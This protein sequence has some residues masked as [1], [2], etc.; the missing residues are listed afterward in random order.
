[1]AE[2]DTKQLGDVLSQAPFGEP[3]V[4]PLAVMFKAA[5]SVSVKLFGLC[6]PKDNR[7][8]DL[9]GTVP[10]VEGPMPEKGVSV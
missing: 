2:S 1:M 5:S 10:D 9:K 4:G 7:F 6:F 8:L 3:T